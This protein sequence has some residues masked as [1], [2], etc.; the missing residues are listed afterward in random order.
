MIKPVQLHVVYLII[1]IILQSLTKMAYIYFFL[2]NA[3]RCGI[4]SRKSIFQNFIDGR[5]DIIFN[6]QD[7]VIL[8]EN[9]YNKFA[10]FYQ[11]GSN[12]YTMFKLHLS[13]YVQV[14]YLFPLRKIIIL[15]IACSRFHSK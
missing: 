5:R 3:N 9:N 11:S 12:S 4:L 1:H 8:P 7:L 2:A 13:T 6:F 10:F 15:E 14:L